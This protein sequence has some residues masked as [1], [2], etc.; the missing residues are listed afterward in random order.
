[1]AGRAGPRRPQLQPAGDVPGR[2][3]AGRPVRVQAADRGRLCA[4]HRRLRHPRPG[5]LAA[6]AAGGVRGHR[7]RRGAVQPG[8]TGLS[9]RR[10][11]RAPAGGVRAVQRLLPGGHSARPAGGH[12][13]DR[14][15][16]PRHL[17]GRV[18]DLRGAEPGADPRAAGPRGRR[19]GARRRRGDGARPMAAGAGQPAVPALLRRHDRRLCALVPGLSG[20][21]AGGETPGRR[22]AVR[23]RRG[24]GAVRRVG[25]EHHRRADQ[26][27]GLVQ[28]PPG[29]RPGPGLGAAGDG[30]GVRAGP[31]GRCATGARTGRGPLGAGGAAAGAGRPAARRRHDDHLPVR[32]GHPR[33]AVR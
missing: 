23:H 13:A 4:A 32:D 7:A 11:G 15:G 12:G 9:G 1:M 18:R 27:D 10:G 21:A 14:A 20:A 17:P 30:A 3:H 25:A 28:G 26:G 22:G 6:R 19:A 29:A 2:R 16:L 5:R 31:G 24:G 33:P 8:G